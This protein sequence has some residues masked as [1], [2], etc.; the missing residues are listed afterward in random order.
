[1]TYNINAKNYN[2]NKDLEFCELKINPNI[3]CIEYG[4]IYPTNEFGYRNYTKPAVD[5]PILGCM[6][7]YINIYGI[8]NDPGHF[9][10]K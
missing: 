4:R 1:M 3:N 9:T 8:R 5:S 2:Q 6:Q 7:F 10:K